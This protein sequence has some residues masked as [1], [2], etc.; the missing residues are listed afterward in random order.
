MYTPRPVNGGRGDADSLG[1]LPEFD[2]PEGVSSLGQGLAATGELTAAEHLI[3]E[4]SFDGQVFVPDH[5][6]A[7]GRRGQ[8]SGEIL[9]SNITV[10]GRATG[11]LIADRVEIADGATVEGEIVTERLVITDGAV[12]QG[13]VDPSRADAAFAVFR[14][15]RS[16]RG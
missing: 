15:E 7:I 14:H 2:L 5:D 6:V 13:V 11:R 12:F 1:S 10:L 9:A 3:I 8:V 4:G 16:R